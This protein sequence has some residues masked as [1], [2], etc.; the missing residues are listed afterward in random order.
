M[1]LA[2]A[3]AAGAW[4]ENPQEL[5][6]LSDGCLC[7]VGMPGMTIFTASVPDPEQSCSEI[8]AAEATGMKPAGTKTFI[9]NAN[10]MIHA[11]SVR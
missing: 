4:P 1:S 8:V 9:S 6:P 2:R 7:S 10:A 3:M 5:S 11:E